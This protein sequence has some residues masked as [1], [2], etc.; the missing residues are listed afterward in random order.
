M[1]VKICGITTPEDAQV[2]IEA[3]A[4][5]LGLVFYP[6]SPRHISI[7]QAQQVAAAVP[8][9]VTLTGLFVNAKPSLVQR[10]LAQVPLNLLQFHGDET[11]TYC[12]QFQRPYI[13]AFAMKPAFEPLAAMAQYPRARGFLL[14]AYRPGVPGGT[15]AVFDWQRVPQNSGHSILLAGGLTE[16]NVAQAIASAK[17]Q[18]VDVS[19]GVEMSPGCKD[20]QKVHDFITAAKAH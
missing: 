2:V 13:K 8:P 5:A 20:P 6:P 1:R 11:A 3:G 15:G 4:D 10:V 18:A 19:G 9:F 12:D 7:D 14:D 16:K 17:P